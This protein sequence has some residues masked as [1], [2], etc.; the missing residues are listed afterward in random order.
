M[1]GNLIMSNQTTIPIS[2]ARAN[3]FDIAE[4]VQK[5]GRIYTLTEKG[6]PKAVLMSADEFDS[7]TE[8]LEILEQFPNIQR[9]VK[10]I[11]EDVKSGAWKDY[12]SLN[13][14][15][16][17]TKKKKSAETYALSSKARKA[18]PKRII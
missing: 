7:L 13:K 18:S 11:N 5:P 15:L 6:R 14:I 8:T 9:E 2:K 16:M 3:I 4:D 1:K 12:I 17:D 10:K